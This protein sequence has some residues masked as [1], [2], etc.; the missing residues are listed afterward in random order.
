[1]L[2]DVLATTVP[3][4][5]PAYDLIDDGTIDL[6]DATELITGLIGTSMA[7]TDLDFEVGLT[8][9]GNLAAAYK[10]P[11]SFADGDTDADGFVGLLDLG[12]LAED[13]GKTFAPTIVPEPTS[14]I[15]LAAGGVVLLRRR[16]ANMPPR[17]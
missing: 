14:L 16:R 7:D 5:D 4:T 9:L 2:W 13:Y 3:P 10:Q 8:D 17:E 15:S 11:G 6:S 1:M 12:N